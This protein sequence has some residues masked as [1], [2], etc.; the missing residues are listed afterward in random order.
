MYARLNLATKPLVS[1]RRFL[2]GAALLG[3]LGG[4]LFLLLGWRFYS[5]FKADEQYRARTGKIQAEMSWLMDQ[6]HELD[7]FYA[8]E[9]N[10]NLQERAKFINGVVEAASFNWTKMFMD[11][12]HTLPA[13]VRVIH[14]EPKL[15]RGT[16]SVKFVVGASNRE[17]KEQLLK[18][19]EDSKSFSH[20]ELYAVDVPKQT[21][22]D[23]LTVEF[24]AVYTGI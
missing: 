16:V 15:D 3:F 10:R 6:R 7:R 18:A 19:F 2:V 5:V 13:G 24:S 14:I 9:A 8:Q 11:L 4:V 17:A 12:E 21:S 22:A 1:H 20:V 23:A